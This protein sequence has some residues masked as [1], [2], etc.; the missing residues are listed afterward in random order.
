MNKLLEIFFLPPNAVARVGSGDTPVEAYEWA[1]DTT[2]HGGT[3]TI[4]KPAVT[5]EVTD[6]GEISCYLPTSIHFKDPDGKIRPVAPFFELWARIQIAED[7]SVQE[8]PMTLSLLKHLGLGLKDVQYRITAGNQKAARRTQQASC[9]FTAEAVINGDDHAPHDLNAYSRHTGGEQPLVFRDKPIYVGRLQV[10]RPVH[11][12]WPSAEDPQIDLSVLRLRFTPPPGRVYGPPTA[13]SGPSSP[14][15]QGLLDPPSSEYGNVHEIVRKEFRIL[16]DQTPWSNSYAWGTGQYDDPQPQDGYDG[17]DVGTY[18]SWGSIDDVTDAV[19]QADL[20]WRGERFTAAARVFTGPPDFAPDRRPFYSIADDLAD[21]ELPA[22][23]IT[24]DTL[25]QTESEILDLFERAY[26]TASLFSLD[27]ARFRGLVENKTDGP[28][29]PTPK[30]VPATD[31]RSMTQWDTPYVD[32]LPSL[33]QPQKPSINTNAGDHNR[34]PYTNV[35]KFVHS[36]MIDRNLLVDFLRRRKDYVQRLIRPPVGSFSQLEVSP[37]P[38]PNPN[39]R[40]PRVP[41]DRYHDMRMP[42]YM[43]DANI[44]PLSITR[45]QYATL[46]KFLNALDSQKEQ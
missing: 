25:Q 20:A 24:T 12:A 7:G 31:G 37:G 17:A 38:Q 26:E 16:N 30:D 36:Q 29:D 34:L 46:M 3:Q 27:A 41:R 6:N 39:F 35:V 4:V 40:D 42:P 33:T 11:G 21:R 44:M 18:M 32:K 13:V 43:R 8:Q 10:I 14:L 23:T 22:P 5:F 9:S 19:I 15:P 2:A 28:L 45:R 1:E